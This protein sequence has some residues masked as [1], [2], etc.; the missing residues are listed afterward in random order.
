MPFL[1][2]NSLSVVRKRSLPWFCWRQDDSHRLG[3]P[4]NRLRDKDS[5]AGG[6]FGKSARCQQGSREEG[7]GKARGLRQ[8]PQRTAGARSRGAGLCGK[9]A[10]CVIDFSILRGV[11]IHSLAGKLPKIHT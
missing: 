8:P 2:L 9:Y 1:G 11:I 5:R 4:R 3:P 6:V 10:T 7:A